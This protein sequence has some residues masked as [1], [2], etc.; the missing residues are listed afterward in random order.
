MAGYNVLYVI[1]WEGEPPDAPIK[2]GKANDIVNRFAGYRT[3]SWRDI[4]VKELFFVKCSDGVVFDRQLK[5]TFYSDEDDAALKLIDGM[6]NESIVVIESAVHDALRAKGLHHRG[7]WFVGGADVIV[8]TARSIIRED[9]GAE[10]ETSRSMLRKLRMWNIEA[11][12]QEHRK[13]HPIGVDRS[14]I[15]ATRYATE[16]LKYQRVR[17]PKRVAAK[18]GF[19]Y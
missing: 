19:R 1:G 12:E 9:F 8:E 18:P 10:Y 2:V 7:E 5:N 11:E 15:A 14:T 13:K 17:G 6:T 3:G 4:A 16:N